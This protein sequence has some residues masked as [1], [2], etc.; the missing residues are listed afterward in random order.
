M[1]ASQPNQ[2]TQFL[3]YASDGTFRDATEAIIDIRRNY[4]MDAGAQIS[5]NV[6]DE[7]CKMLKAGYFRN[8][9]SY[10]WGGENWVVNAIN[11]Q[12]GEGNGAS[13]SMELLE[14]KFHLLKND[15][16]PQNF[17]AANGFSFAQKVAK[18]YKLK[19]VGEKVKGKQQT[20]KVKAKNNRESV[21][22]VLQRSASDNQYLCFIA[23]NT[24]F[25]ASPKFLIGRW[26]TKQISYRPAGKVKEEPF[27]F[28]PLVYPT[29]D[30]TKDFFLIGLPSMRR[31]L[32]SKKEA[33][34]SASLFGPSARNLRAGMTV[35]VYGLGAAFDLAYLI[36]SVDFDEYSTEPTEINFA[37][38]ASLSPED[39]AKVDKKIS[40]VTVISGS[41]S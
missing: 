35:M 40:E 9:T 26:G 17:R 16:Q 38:V 29:P 1:S 21:W 37:N 19:F 36:T 14:R 8:G 6:Y 25:F 2:R 33:E 34:G 5:V 15:F 30:E 39:K 3:L 20:I 10:V 31:A 11:V 27:L 18:K 13:V 4:T 7:E 23:D 28:V 41:G 24:L 32:D 22:S 12:Q